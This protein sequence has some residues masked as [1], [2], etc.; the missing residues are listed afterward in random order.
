MSGA[1]F[2]P[3]PRVQRSKLY[4]DLFQVGHLALKKPFCMKTHHIKYSKIHMMSPVSL[5]H[6]V[7]HENWGFDYSSLFGSHTRSHP[8][9]KGS[10]TQPYPMCHPF[11]KQGTRSPEVWSEC[12]R[13][14][15][16]HFCEVLHSPTGPLEK[17]YPHKGHAAT[18]QRRSYGGNTIPV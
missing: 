7:S 5:K 14:P 3:Q 16:P 17:G 15:T 11:H 2:S 12:S 8:P 4:T 10:I 18:P 9:G 6:H 13:S 1:E